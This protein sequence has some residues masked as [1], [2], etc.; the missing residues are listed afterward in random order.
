MVRLRALVLLLAPLTL[1][2]ASPGTTGEPS[3][4]RK[5]LLSIDLAKSTGEVTI[6]ATGFLLV[7]RYQSM[8]RTAQRT[9]ATVTAPIVVTVAGIGDA[10]IIPTDSAAT[11]VA[12]V[13]LSGQEEA[14][15]VRYTGAALRVTRSGATLPYYVNAVPKAKSGGR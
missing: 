10:E 3:I 7:G 5:E 9:V 6:V 2:A 8:E 14:G 4:L 1:V 11:I 12:D 13:Y 15:R